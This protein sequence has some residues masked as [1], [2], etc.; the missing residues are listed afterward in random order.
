M[1][2]W[3]RGSDGLDAD[4]S[5][6]IPWLKSLCC[7]SEL[8]HLRRWLAFRPRPRA[9]PRRTQGNRRV[10]RFQV[11]ADL[12]LD[13]RPSPTC[14]NARVLLA[15]SPDSG[16]MG[17]SACVGSG[18]VADQTV[19]ASSAERFP[20]SGGRW[21]SGPTVM[22][23]ASDWPRLDYPTI[24]THH[25]LRFLPLQRACRSPASHFGRGPLS[26]IHHRSRMCRKE[27]IMAS[28]KLPSAKCRLPSLQ[29]QSPV[30]LQLSKV[31]FVFLL[32]RSLLGCLA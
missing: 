2:V 22:R 29:V 14:K 26:K 23:Q 3:R 10:E 15:D 21:R 24:R 32:P 27:Q 9:R 4:A 1:P 25:P 31:K 17:K 30:L 13:L 12:A 28:P 19:V 16:D 5:M 8:A 18:P 6:V 20:S 7:A 11:A